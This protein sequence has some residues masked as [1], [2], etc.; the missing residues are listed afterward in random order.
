[1][2]N[3]TA[4]EWMLVSGGNET[5]IDEEG[6]TVYASRMTGAPGLGS[7]TWR[8]Y[9][10]RNTT[11]PPP[12]DTG[13]SGAESIDDETQPM[14]EV[15]ITASRFEHTEVNQAG[16]HRVLEFLL[17]IVGGWILKE[18]WDSLSGLAEYRE[19]TGTMDL[20]Q[21]ARDENG[22]LRTG[23]ATNML[24]VRY[25]IR[26]STDGSWWVD[27]DRDGKFESNFR[28]NTITGYLE[29][30]EDNRGNFWTPCLRA[31]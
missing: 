26:F 12:A 15:V 7:S 10:N 27:L 20:N 11:P 23:E 1:M 13:G 28:M 25:E 16:Y 3:L 9:R 17:G 18:A 30:N 24:G 22:E 6:V 19:G 8:F 14:E 29:V 5:T 31:D 4:E 21:W 2:R